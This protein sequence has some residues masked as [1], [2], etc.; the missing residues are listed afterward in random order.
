MLS[1]VN[2]PEIK[3]EINAYVLHYNMGT[4]CATRCLLFDFFLGTRLASKHSDGLMAKIRFHSDNN[5]T[6]ANPHYIR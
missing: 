4:Y 2:G 3:Q 5:V 6:S 1:P